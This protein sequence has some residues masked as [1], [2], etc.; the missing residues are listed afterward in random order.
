M[1]WSHC[2]LML[3]Q[4]SSI[5]AQRWSNIH[6]HHYGWTSSPLVSNSSCHMLKFAGHRP[7]K[8]KMLCATLVGQYNTSFCDMPAIDKLRIFLSPYINK[9]TVVLTS[10]QSTS[11]SCQLHQ[12]LLLP[13][14]LIKCVLEVPVFKLQLQLWILTRYC[15]ICQQCLQGRAVSYCISHGRLPW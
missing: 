3:K 1:C 7:A 4:W 13:Y 5:S 15:M 11:Q 6:A 10:L 9:L 14:L 12:H 8:N 2:L